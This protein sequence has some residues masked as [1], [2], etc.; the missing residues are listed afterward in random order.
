MSALTRVPAEKSG[1]TLSSTLLARLREAIMS[2]ALVPGTKLHLDSM[3]ASFGVSLSP[4]REALCRLESERLVEITDHRGYRVADVSSRNLAEVLSLRVLLETIALESAIDRGDATWESEILAALHRLNAAKRSAPSG[5]D[6]ENWE[7]CHRHFHAALIGAAQ[8]PMLQQFCSLL[9]DQSDRYRRIFLL[10]REPDRDVP[11]EHAA[12]ADAV[13][14]RRK[15]AAIS[16]LTAHIERTGSNVMRVL[17]EQDGHS[18]AIAV[19]RPSGLG[20]AQHVSGTSIPKPAR[21][22]KG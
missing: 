18:P 8:M 16:L 21:K 7:R 10:R 2:G 14:S 12:I 19:A 9:H 11:A 13:V 20:E 15:E 6:Q 4:L 17:L 22:R 1:V 3:R 5:A